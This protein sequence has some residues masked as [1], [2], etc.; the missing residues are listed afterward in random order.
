M[1]S[2]IFETVTIR[3]TLTEEEG[4]FLKK[5]IKRCWEDNQ[6]IHTRRD[7]E[8]MKDLFQSLEGI[9]E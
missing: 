2:E 8:I 4:F 7:Q 9:Q 6:T 1:E 3:L 5:L